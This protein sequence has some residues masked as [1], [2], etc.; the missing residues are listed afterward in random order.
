MLKVL[1]SILLTFHC[2]TRARPFSS[3]RTTITTTKKHI[4][5]QGLLRKQFMFLLFHKVCSQGFILCVNR[6]IA[7]VTVLNTL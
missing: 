7:H 5:I 4:W 6:T 3:K 1:A 2:V